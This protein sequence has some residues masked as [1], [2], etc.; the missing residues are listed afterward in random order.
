MS[1]R[2]LVHVVDDNEEIR[3][4]LAALLRSVAIETKTHADADALIEAMNASPKPG[5]AIV[6]DVRLPGISGISL[7]ERLRRDHPGIP[8]IMITG[9]GDVDMAVHTMKLGAVDFI[10]KPFSGQVLLERLQT[11]L[12]RSRATAVGISTSEALQRL[13]SLSARERQVFDRIVAGDANRAI[14]E[15]LGIS[16]RTVESHRAKVMEKTGA[17]TLVELVLLSVAAG[18]P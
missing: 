14:A 8:V 13:A 12:R 2:P 11:V 16:V 5:D 18:G 3:R 17:R 1:E 10:T 7:L 15:T 9:Y 6:L 4:S